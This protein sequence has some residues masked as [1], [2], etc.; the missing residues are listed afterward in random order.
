MVDKAGLAPA[1]DAD[2]SKLCKNNPLILIDG[3]QGSGEE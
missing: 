2:T 1:R 3:K